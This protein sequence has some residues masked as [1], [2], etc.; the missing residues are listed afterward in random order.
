MK[1]GIMQPYLFP[2]LGYF[3]LIFAVDAFILYDDVSYIRQGWINRNRILCNGQPH[4][5]TVPIS[6][7]SS[8]VSIKDTRVDESRYERWRCSFFKTVEQ[9]YKKAAPFYHETLDILVSVLTSPPSSIADFASRSITTVLE[10]IGITREISSSYNR[11]S[12]HFLT[13]QSRIL[14]ICR[15]EGSD[16]YINAF[17]GASIYN[18]EDFH[19]AGVML[20]FIRMRPII[21]SQAQTAFMPNLSIIDVLMRCGKRQTAKMLMEFDLI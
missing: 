2:Y 15:Q 9:N 17:G 19:A 13:G 20:S 10:H 3:Q 11:F 4:Y 7:S 5:F 12:N 16:H 8:F 18:K 14:D 21:Y 1:L 6:K